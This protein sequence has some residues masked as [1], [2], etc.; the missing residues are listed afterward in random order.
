MPP[1]TLAERMRNRPP[2]DPKAWSKAFGGTKAV[3]PAAEDAAGGVT[4][5]GC[6]VL[7]ETDLALWVTGVVAGGVPV[8]IPK[9]VCAVDP[10]DLRVECTITL[11]R[12]FA[13][14]EGWV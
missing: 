7:N 11:Q 9:S 5:D 3:E 6:C 1:K 8:W 4:F 13:A 12:W 14:K 2:V 10:P